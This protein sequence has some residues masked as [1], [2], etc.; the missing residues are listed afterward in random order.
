[1]IYRDEVGHVAIGNR[2]FNHLCGQRRQQPAQTFLQLL[3]DYQVP[4]PHPPFN[5]EAR[6]RAG[7]EAEEL[8][9]WLI[10]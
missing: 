10:E 4:P 1:V 8:A 5:E 3:E 9:S 7:F 6:L 2:W